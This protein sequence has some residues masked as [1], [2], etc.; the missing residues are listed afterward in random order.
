MSFYKTE[1]PDPDIW[2][3]PT[4][5]HA[6]HKSYSCRACGTPLGSHGV[7]FWN[8]WPWCAEHYQQMTALAMDQVTRDLAGEEAAS[9]ADIE[10]DD[11]PIYNK[12]RR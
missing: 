9:R 2:D 7:K 3:D 8:G 12:V 11:A 10:R 6:E 5:H 1:P 4:P